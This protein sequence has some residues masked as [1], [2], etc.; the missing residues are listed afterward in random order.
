MT[1]ISKLTN[2][3]PFHYF[4]LKPL[5]CINFNN[6]FVTYL[7]KKNNDSY[8]NKIRDLNPNYTH[9][10]SKQTAMPLS[11][12]TLNTITCLMLSVNTI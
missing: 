11:Y 7:K 1:L 3:V 6:I 2:K 8:E 5:Y 12:Y 9:D 4:K 10:K